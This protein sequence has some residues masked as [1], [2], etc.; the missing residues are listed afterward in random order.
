VIFSNHHLLVVDKPPGWRSIPL[1]AADYKSKQDGQKC[2]LSFLKNQS[3][4]GGSLKDYLKPV[5]R[6]DQPC[7]GLTVF[8]KNSKAASRI[9]K[10]WAKRQVSKEYYCVVQAENLESIYNR[11]IRW[12]DFHAEKQFNKHHQQWGDAE[13]QDKNKV[14]VLSGILSKRPD[15]RGSVRMVS[16]NGNGLLQPRGRKIHDEDSKPDERTHGT[17]CHLEFRILSSNTNHNDHQLLTHHLIAVRTTTGMRHQIRAML[18]RVGK[19]PIVGDLRY[20]ANKQPLSDKS[21][22]L[23]AKALYMPTV[24]LGGTDLVTKHFVAPIPVTWERYFGISESNLNAK[25]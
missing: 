17:V 9:Q 11:A 23:H 19:C 6:L 16:S 10:A 14:Y 2:L 4:G 22:A 7:S 21:V 1:D 15:G 18:A 13:W 24:K 20:G 8:A 5:H 12:S 25:I 3:M